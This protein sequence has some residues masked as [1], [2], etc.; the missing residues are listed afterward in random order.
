MLAGATD[1][2]S[3]RAEGLSP[4]DNVARELTQ[5]AQQISNSQKLTEQDFRQQNLK[6]LIDTLPFN[7]VHIATHGTFSSNPEQTYLLD[8]N[9][10]IK[11]K[12]LDNLL[13]VREEQISTPIELLV[14]SACETARGDERELAAL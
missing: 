2:P 12:D 1:A 13:R 3:F 10:R 6:N 9:K 5:V 4:I 7:V 8:W 11:V 14:L